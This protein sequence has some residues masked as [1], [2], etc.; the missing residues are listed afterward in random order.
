MSG[1][2]DKLRSIAQQ[3][4]EAAA[5]NNLSAI[6]QLAAQVE[7]MAGGRPV[8]SQ[9][10]AV[11]TGQGDAHMAPNVAPATGGQATVGNTPGATDAPVAA[12]DSKNN[13]HRKG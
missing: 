5:T 3:L 1:Q 6:H 7:A 11:I 10:E 9:P 8:G 4:N 2:A 13:T 12:T